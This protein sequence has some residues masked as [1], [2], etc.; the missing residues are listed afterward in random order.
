V[1]VN[2]PQALRCCLGV[3]YD[4]GVSLRYHGVFK[5]LSKADGTLTLVLGSYDILATKNTLKK[6]VFVDKYLFKG[7]PAIS[8]S[9]FTKELGKA[10]IITNEN[11]YDLFPQSEIIITSAGGTAV[12]AVACGLSVIVVG[13]A[14]DLINNTLLEYG[15]GQIWDFVVTET[16]LKDAYQNLLKYR[17]E[18]F[19]KIK[20]IS[21]WYRNNFFIEPTKRNISKIFS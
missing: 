1:L 21:S 15:K 2:G 20:V 8:D 9:I 11:I 17:S 12:E 19:E 18:Q 4:V 7:H 6:L 16:D 10:G 5:V 13:S 3:E 14:D